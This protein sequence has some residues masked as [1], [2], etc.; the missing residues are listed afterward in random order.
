[1][2]KQ[3]VPSGFNMSAAENGTYSQNNIFVRD[4][5]PRVSMELMDKFETPVFSVT[6]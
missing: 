1:M 5:R 3:C 2:D 6:V 4:I